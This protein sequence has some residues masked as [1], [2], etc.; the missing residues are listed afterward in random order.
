MAR[1][2]LTNI[3]LNK[4]QL[5]NTVIQNVAVDPAG[6][7]GQIIFNTAANVFKYYNGTKWVTLDVSKDEINAQITNI[8]VS[9]INW[10]GVDQG[11]AASIVTALNKGK[12]GTVKL[13]RKLVDGLDQALQNASMTGEAIVD[14]VN[15]Q[16]AKK[17]Q[18]AKI[19]G[20]DNIAQTKA[21]NALNQAKTYAD[22]IKTALI[23]SASTD[24]DT[25]K[26][27]ETAIKR[28]ASALQAISGVT[29]KFTKEIG[30]SVALKHAVVHNLNTRD[31][32]VQV[33]TATA[34]YEVVEADITIKDNNTIEVETAT[35]IQASAKLKV[36]VIG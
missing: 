14:A 21:D 7:K 1:N 34:P 11:K 15:G 17:I 20:I 24:Y 4:N 8:D 32:I 36:V 6:V 2:F 31:V 10:A 16:S 28:N 18:A 30:D 19:D 26:E 29:K 5:L 35:P 13:D 22:G 3:D 33:S 27:I 12:D 9:K 25:F 23:N